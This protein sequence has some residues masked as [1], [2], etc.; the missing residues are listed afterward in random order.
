MLNTQLDHRGYSFF[1]ILKFNINYHYNKI[2][3]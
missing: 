2:N 1:M 3:L